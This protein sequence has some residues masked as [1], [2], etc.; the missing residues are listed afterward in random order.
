MKIRTGFVSNSSSSS[1]IIVFDKEITSKEVLA[2]QLGTCDPRQR[3]WNEPYDNTYTDNGG[4][5]I[6]DVVYKLI[7]KELSAEYEPFKTVDDAIDYMVRDKMYEDFTEEKD[8]YQEHDPERFDSLFTNGPNGNYWHLDFDKPETKR[9]MNLHI[10]DMKKDYDE[11][12]KDKFTYII[13]VDDHAWCD[14]EHGNVFRNVTHKRI[15]KH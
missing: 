6:V 10:E 7:K 11:V 1:F 12:S 14:I 9:I 13:E 3:G 8:Y 4:S 5:D 15:S 2:E